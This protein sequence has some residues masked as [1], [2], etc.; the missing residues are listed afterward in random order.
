LRRPVPARDLERLAWPVE[1]MQGEARLFSK[2]HAVATA[3]RRIEPCLQHRDV[4]AQRRVTEPLLS[5]G[6]TQ[7]QGIDPGLALEQ[8]PRVGG[9]ALVQQE[10]GVGAEQLWIAQVH[11]ES[12]L[13]MRLR[14]AAVA[15][16]RGE[17]G[18]DGE[19]PDSDLGSGVG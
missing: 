14:A 2:M 7:Q 18:Q 11:G 4:L 9:A 16:L 10:I 5:Q 3:A 1:Q 19:R 8:R 15:L 17:L 13:E 6:E 12:C